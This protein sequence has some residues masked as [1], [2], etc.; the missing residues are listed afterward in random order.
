MISPETA[1][2]EPSW[3]T[4]ERYAIYDL[5]PNSAIAFP[6]HDEVLNL[7]NTQNVYKVCGYAYSGGGKRITRVELSLDQGCTWRF[8]DI[9]YP[10]DE[11]RD[12]SAQRLYDGT[13]DMSE[14]E[15]SFCWS[16][17]NVEVDVGELTEAHD[18]VVRAM[19][20]GMCIQPRDLYWNVMGMMNNPWFRV[21]IHKENGELRFEHPT[22]PALQAGGWM[23]RVKKAGGDVANG[24]WGERIGD[25]SPHI[26]PENDA[27]EISMKNPEVSESISVEQLREHEVEDSPWFVVEGEVY[28][29][30]SFLKEH[31]GGAQS[32]ES[33]AGQ[34][35][36]EEFLAIHSETARAQMKDFHIGSLHED[37]KAALS[38]SQAEPRQSNSGP[39]DTFLEPR[40][41]KKAALHCKSNVSWD[42]RL[43]T[44]KLDHEEQQLGLPV[45]HHVLLK[46]RDPASRELL[47]RSYTPISRT[48]KKGFVDVLVK[49]Y[50]DTKLRKGG[51]MSQAMESLPLGHTIEF[52]GPLGR[53]EYLGSGKCRFNGG[54]RRIGTLI[55]VCAGTGI[56]PMH[57]I[58]TNVMG[59]N[60]DSTRCIVLNG[61]RM[62]E[63]IL[64]KDELDGFAAANKHKC[65]IYFSLTKASDGWEGI[66][67]RIDPPLLKRHAGRSLHGASEAMVLICGPEGFE[68]SVRQALMDDGWGEE[69]IVL[70]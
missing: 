20:E 5:S 4:D 41:W 15:A 51:K 34:D 23:E 26:V 58:L 70:F 25:D 69:D 35:V 28:D 11:Y 19:D 64:C 63:D 66:Q 48:T 40:N 55:M 18:L 56:T 45:G 60:D 43:F 12:A 57:Q 46:L 36:T 54:E 7:D 62:L 42:T 31:P 30:T 27:A 14:Q 16:F 24:Y 6:A 1:A 9:D 65:E 21:A 29:G 38:N 50:F 59:D 52:K 8:A 68:K 49:V 47:M 44:F 10:E 33:A 37:G 13:M 17:W 22:Q 2:N 53:F 3:W 67:G 61:N 39:S 32:I